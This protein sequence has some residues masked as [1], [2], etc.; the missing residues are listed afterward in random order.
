MIK[1]WVLKDHGRTVSYRVE[2][3]AGWADFGDDIVCAAV[4]ALVI[5]AENG[6]CEVAGAVEKATS[7]DGFLEVEL[8]R[9]L[10]ERSS[11]QAEAII[12]AMVV[13]LRAIAEQYPDRINIFE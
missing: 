7:E 3:H 8:K 13:A 5:G 9:V 4:S 1:V 11:I 2:G 6:L 12:G 10:D